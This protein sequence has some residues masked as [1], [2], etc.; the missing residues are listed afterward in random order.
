MTLARIV[1][2]APDRVAFLSQYLRSRGYTVELIY[3]GAVQGGTAELQLGFQECSSE[4][5]PARKTDMTEGAYDGR[6]VVAYDITGRPVE[7]EEEEPEA[8]AGSTAFAEAWQGLRST[9]SKLVDKL[10]LSSGH[11][12]ESLANRRQSLDEYRVRYHQL[13]ANA[14]AQAE[15]SRRERLAQRQAFQAERSR[16]KLE[17]ARRKAENDIAQERLQAETRQWQQEVRLAGA[18]LPDHEPNNFPQ[19]H[20]YRRDED[21]RK[22]AVAAAVLAMLAI[23]GLAGY[24]NRLGTAPFSHPE[25]VQSQDVSKPVP[26]A[27]ATTPVQPSATPRAV[28]LASGVGHSRIVSVPQSDAPVARTAALPVARKHPVRRTHADED[29]FIAEDEVIV[30]RRQPSGTVQARSHAGTGPRRIS[31]LD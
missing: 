19:P 3:P 6:R 16:R 12:R 14:A 20:R 27:V 9:R 15:E 10:R 4:E 17:K 11:L 21:L 26:F 30:H 8:V 25:L 22:A 29:E 28:N 7:F 13:R 1:T 2:N 24:R 5:A 31:D 23:V 18:A